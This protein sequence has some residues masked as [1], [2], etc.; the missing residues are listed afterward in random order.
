MYLLY[1]WASEH[2]LQTMYPIHFILQR[3]PPSLEG[4]FRSCTVHQFVCGPLLCCMQRYKMSVRVAGVEP[5]SHHFQ[6]ADRVP[7][8]TRVFRTPSPSPVPSGSHARQT[9]NSDVELRSYISLRT[10]VAVPDAFNGTFSL[11]PT[12][13]YLTCAGEGPGGEKVIASSSGMWELGL[14][15]FAT[16]FLHLYGAKIRALHTFH[17]EFCS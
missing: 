7:K 1:T 3:I 16:R 17:F 8:C 12:A 11:P 6:S 2:L 9:C 10:S 15:D 14:S 4:L 13:P 5:A